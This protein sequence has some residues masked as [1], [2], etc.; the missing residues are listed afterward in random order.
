MS[1]HEVQEV[2]LGVVQ[3]STKVRFSYLPLPSLSPTPPLS[4]SFKFSS[5]PHLLSLY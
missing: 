4:L 5:H 2:S 3:G 1:T